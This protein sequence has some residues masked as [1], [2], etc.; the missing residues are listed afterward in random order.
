MLPDTGTPN[1]VDV[2]LVAVAEVTKVHFPLEIAWSRTLLH[3]AVV[4]AVVW[5]PARS[6]SVRDSGARAAL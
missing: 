2:W 1:A 4:M 3:G 5:G 6:N